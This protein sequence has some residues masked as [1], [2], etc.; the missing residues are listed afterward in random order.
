MDKPPSA[1]NVRATA[2]QEESRTYVLKSAVNKSQPKNYII[3]R[4]PNATKDFDLGK[5]PQPLHMHREDQNY[6]NENGEPR[7]IPR[8]YKN[9]SAIKKY[10]WVIE[11][12]P[13][14][15]GEKGHQFIGTIEPDQT[16]K[17]VLFVMASNNSDEFRVYPVDDWY[18]FRPKAAISHIS[19]EEAELKLK[20]VED[21]K[22]GY[23]DKYKPKSEI[24]EEQIDDDDDREKHPRGRG[25]KKSKIAKPAPKIERD[26]DGEDNAEYMDFDKSWSDDDEALTLDPEG[27]EDQEK[28]TNQGSKKKKKLSETGKELKKKILNKEKSRRFTI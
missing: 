20:V 13:I 22:K 6:R 24:K 9:P 12:S 5:L 18:N 4:F 19:L 26:A 17:Y 2:K 14:K 11:D 27:E 1:T 10:P 21:T 15:D 3:S 28:N 7:I 8:G 16:S 25:D 23:A